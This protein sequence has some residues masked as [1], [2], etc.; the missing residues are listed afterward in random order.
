MGDYLVSAYGFTDERRYVYVLDAH[1]GT[2]V[3]RLP[4]VENICPRKEFANYKVCDVPGQV[5][6]AASSPRVEDGLFLV[7]TNIGSSA[8]QFK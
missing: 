1:S 6:G 4:V 8:F 7:D 3:Q 2:V 5:V